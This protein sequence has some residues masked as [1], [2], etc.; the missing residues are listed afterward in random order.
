MTKLL[1]AALAAFVSGLGMTLGIGTGLLVIY[2]IA[3]HLVGA[4]AP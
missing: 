4:I 3:I 2:F 1:S